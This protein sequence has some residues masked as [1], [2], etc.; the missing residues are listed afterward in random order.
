LGIRYQQNVKLFYKEKLHN[1]VA[2]N[3]VIHEMTKSGKVGG[4]WR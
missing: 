3:F 4:L 1:F 2:H